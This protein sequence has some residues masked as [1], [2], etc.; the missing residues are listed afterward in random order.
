MVSACQAVVRP[1]GSE[2]VACV[3]ALSWRGPTR[4]NYGCSLEESSPHHKM[5]SVST[6]FGRNGTRSLAAL[7]AKAAI[8]STQKPTSRRSVSHTRACA[9]AFVKGF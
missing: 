7:Q 5:P 2:S 8:A 6:T 1:R 9:G 4:R 3:I